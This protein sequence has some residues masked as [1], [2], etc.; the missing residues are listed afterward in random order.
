[1]YIESIW[2]RAEFLC[3]SVLLF[4]ISPCNLTSL[5]E[6]RNLFKIL[7]FYWF[8]GTTQENGKYG[9]PFIHTHNIQYIYIYKYCCTCRSE[10][11]TQ[12]K[13][14][15]TTLSRTTVASSSCFTWVTWLHF[16]GGCVSENLSA[17]TPFTV[18][19]LCRANNQPEDKPNR[20]C[21]KRNVGSGHLRLWPQCLLSEHTKTRHDYALAHSRQYI[22]ITFSINDNHLVI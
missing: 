16:T 19:V 18:I 14:A 6:E 20:I 21:H 11:L 1:M 5:K 9:K 12:L 17:F 15:R 4:T 13:G 3:L 8:C 7:H 2:D 10:T 22:L